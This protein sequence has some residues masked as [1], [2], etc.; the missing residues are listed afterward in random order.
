VTSVGHVEKHHR[1]PCARC[2]HAHSRHQTKVPHCQVTGC[3]CAGWKAPAGDRETWRARWRDPA[4]KERSKTFARKIDAER[5]LLSTEDSKLRGAYVDPAAGRIP[6]GEWAERWYSS[7]AHLKPSTRHDYRALLDHQVLPTFRETALAWIDAL[8]IKEWRSD[9]LAKGLSA[10]RAG[11][12]LQVL[13]QVLASAVEG[14]RLARNVAD[15]IKP[16]KVQRREMFFLDADQVEAVAEAIDPRYRPLVLF[17]TYT[18]L[19]PCELVALKVGRL[20]LLNCTARVA[21]AAVEVGRLEWGPVKTHEART[22]RMPR[23]VA[24]EIGA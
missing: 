17:A 3:P 5:F 8:T 9:L 11:K 22:V 16:P 14:G 6:F 24:E 10:K 18:G 21:E 13:S 2:Q 15:G 1:K 19:R 12:A 4:G 23:S 20:D 7:T